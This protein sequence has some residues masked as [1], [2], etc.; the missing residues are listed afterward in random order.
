MQRTLDNCTLIKK[1]VKDGIGEPE[2]YY[3]LNKCSGYTKSENNDEPC[4]QCRKCR[5][6]TY[7]GL[8]KR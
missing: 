2:Q 1:L 7:N 8:R 6:C 5:L 4:E 3:N